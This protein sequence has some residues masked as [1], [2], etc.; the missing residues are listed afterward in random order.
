M[1]AYDAAAAAMEIIS[2]IILKKEIKYDHKQLRFFAVNFE[3]INNVTRNEVFAFAFGNAFVAVASDPHLFTFD[4][5]PEALNS[6]DLI[7]IIL[8]SLSKIQTCVFY[9]LVRFCVKS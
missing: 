5:R 2:N 6:T 3:M 4:V 7:R 1:I 9:F 8:N